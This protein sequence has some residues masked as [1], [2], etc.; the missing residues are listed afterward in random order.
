M[1]NDKPFFSIIMPVYNAENFLPKAIDSILNQSYR[2]FELILVDD[3]SSD[4]SLELCIEYL[5]QDNRIKLLKNTFNFGPSV[6]RNKG[7]D[8][9]EGEYIGFID[10]DDY[11][12]EDLLKLIYEE[13]KHS[14]ADIIKFGVVEE[15]YN[16]K[17]ELVSVKKF[18]PGEFILKNQ[19]DIYV[20]FLL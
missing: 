3:C 2:D 16:E 19:E 12:E 17:K 14:S 10:A 5:Q 20:E 6:A 7:L 11:I 9:A 18:S 4:K 1:V 13:V 15:Y 8:N